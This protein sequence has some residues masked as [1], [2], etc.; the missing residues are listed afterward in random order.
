MAHRRWI[1]VED[2][3]TGHRFDVDHRQ[4]DRL[5]QE[6]SVVLVEGYPVN[7]GPNAQP[8]RPKHAT[9]LDGEPRQFGP[10]SGPTSPADVE[11]PAAPAPASASARRGTTRPAT[12]TP[13]ASSEGVVS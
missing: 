4:V 10:P 12:A 3:T 2:T 8:R 7:E 11:T 5:V 6:G 9:G 13:T 1:W